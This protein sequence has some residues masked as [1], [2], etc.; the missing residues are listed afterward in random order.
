MTLDRLIEL[1][2]RY[3]DLHKITTEVIDNTFYHILHSHVDFNK[4][5]VE[6]GMDDLDIIEMYMNVERDLGIEVLDEIWDELFNTLE[7]PL[8]VTQVIRDIKLTQI[9]L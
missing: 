9:G 8:R 5:W 1:C 6:N 3:P 4:T 7:K 2:N